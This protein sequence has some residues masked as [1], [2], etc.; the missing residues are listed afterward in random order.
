MRRAAALEGRGGGG[1]VGGV[2]SRAR[3][4]WQSA[5]RWERAQR[6]GLAA[7][8]TGTGATFVSAGQR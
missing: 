7:H 3:A 5:A 4:G 8:P 2:A 6:R 1:G